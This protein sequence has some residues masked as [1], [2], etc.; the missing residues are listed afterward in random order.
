MNQLE[1]KKIFFVALVLNLILGAISQLD[2][3]WRRI[4]G[5][6]GFFAGIASAGFFLIILLPLCA[7]LSGIIAAIL[8]NTRRVATFFAGVFVSLLLSVV[9]VS[10]ITNYNRAKSA[11]MFSQMY[12]KDPQQ[13]PIGDPLRPVTI[14]TPGARPYDTKPGEVINVTVI[15]LYQPEYNEGLPIE[16]VILSKST[17]NTM[18]NREVVPLGKLIKTNEAQSDGHVTFTGRVTVPTELAGRSDVTYINIVA[19]EMNKDILP[20]RLTGNHAMINEVTH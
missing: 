6:E 5:F 13:R 7:L 11:D 9:L 3:F 14:A 19:G 10:I 18:L 15:A 1:I 20:L 17:R 16:L 2:F 8:S 4:L 12:A